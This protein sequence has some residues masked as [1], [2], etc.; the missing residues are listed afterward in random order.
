MTEQFIFWSVALAIAAAIVVPYYIHHRRRL[1][2]GEERKAEAVLLRI[3]RP[4]GQFPYVDPLKCAGC[5]T[6]VEAC[7]EGDVLGIAGGIAVIINGVRCIGAGACEKACPV[8]AITVGL[9]DVRSRE[10][11]PMLDESLQTNLPGVFIAGELG[12]FSLVS[13]AVR[14]GGVVVDNIASRVA[15][16]GPGGDEAVDLAIVGAGPAGLSAALGAKNAQLSH[17]VLEREEG[18]GGTVLN[19]P[20]RKM[21]LTQTVD[22]AGS[23]QLVQDS[24]QKE[25]LL[26]LFEKA[27]VD[28]D[29]QVR[30]GK[31]VTGLRPEGENYAVEVGEERYLARNVLLALGR[32]G[33]P[34]KMRVPGEEQAKV[35]YRLIDADSYRGERILVVGGGD[36]A[37]EAAMALARNGANEVALSYRKEKLVR[38]KQR[39]QVLVE[40]MI[41]KGWIRPLFPSQVEEVTADTVRLKVADDETLELPND[42]VFV[43]IGG[44]PPFKF[45]RSLGIQFGGEQASA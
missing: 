4:L 37:V 26:K 2:D 16:S 9:G 36:S 20:R 23:M 31:A 34:R 8:D 41:A 7:P 35:M 29:L 12:G 45:L 25:D 6:C 10:D 14:Q 13:N 44:E 39:N 42:Y 21:V 18:L 43:C 19:Y 28:N 17:V 15:A 27:V 1:V 30:F 3:D 40:E 24:Y 32:R 22:I 38:I 11:I 5:A 33:N